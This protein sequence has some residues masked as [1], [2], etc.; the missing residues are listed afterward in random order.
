M[1]MRRLNARR[2]VYYEVNEQ[3]RMSEVLSMLKGEQT[4]LSTDGECTKSS[5]L[6]V[7]ILDQFTEVYSIYALSSL[8]FHCQLHT[9]ITLI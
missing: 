6:I 4:N 5:L 3:R 8:S 2:M 1:S 7:Y 9:V